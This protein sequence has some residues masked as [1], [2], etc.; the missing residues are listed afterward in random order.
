MDEAAVAGFVDGALFTY[1]AAVIKTLTANSKIPVIIHGYDH[2]IPDGSRD[3]ILIDPSGPW[4]LPFFEAR[5]YDIAGNRQH[6]SLASE[7]MKRLFDRLNAAIKKVAAAYPNRVYYVDLTGTLA[8]KY[9]DAAKYNLLWANELHPNEEGFDL[10]AAR[11]AKQLKEL[12][13]G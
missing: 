10:L 2:P 9:G 6:L 1:Y 7:I 3:I 4:L 13:I 8:Q 5:G 12:K 11:V